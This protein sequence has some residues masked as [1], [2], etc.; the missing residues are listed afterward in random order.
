MVDRFQAAALATRLHIPLLYGIDAV[1]GAGGV[2]G[3]GVFPHNIGLGA[4]RDPALIREVEHITAAETR[5]S[6]PQ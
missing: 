1:H 4:S 3:A 5:A 6:G 2:H